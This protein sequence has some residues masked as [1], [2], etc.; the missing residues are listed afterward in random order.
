MAAL[1]L[2][3]T[4]NKIFLI[5][6]ETSFIKEKRLQLNKLCKINQCVLLLLYQF[7]NQSY[8]SP[9][10]GEGVI[11]RFWGSHRFSRGIEGGS[12]AFNRV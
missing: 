5:K 4:K 11:G 7:G 1:I 6:N 12:L 2:V 8:V 9:G 10:R 3:Y